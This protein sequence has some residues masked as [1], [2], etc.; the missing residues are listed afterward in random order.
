MTEARSQHQVFVVRT[1]GEWALAPLPATDPETVDLDGVLAAIGPSPEQ[2]GGP[3]RPAPDPVAPLAGTDLVGPTWMWVG[4]AADGEV[5]VEEPDGTLLVL[6]GPDLELLHTID[7]IRTVDDVVA[8]STVADAAGRLARLAGSGRVVWTAPAEAGAVEPTPEAEPAPDYSHLPPPPA[9]GLIWPQPVAPVAPAEPAEVPGDD[10]IPVYAI[11]PVDVGPLLSLGML[12][13]TARHW[14]DGALNERYE[15]RK[16]ETAASFLDHLAGRQ[17]PAVLLCSDYVWSLAHNLEAAATAR[18][19]CPDLLV[20]HGG[21]SAPKYADDAARFLSDHPAVADVLVRGEGEEALCDLLEALDGPDGWTTDAGRLGTVGGITF[22]AAD[23]EVVRTE[24]RPRIANLDSIP[25]PY[26]SGEF[27]GIPGDAWKY[28]LSIET[29]RGCPYGCTF[30]DWGSATMSRIRKFDLDRVIAELEWGAR[31]G[32]HTIT[33]TD[34]N[35]GIMS[36]DVET[37]RQIAAIR[38]RVGHPHSLSWTAA[39]NT[40]KHLVKIMDILVDSG[41]TVST[42]LS[43]QTIDPTTLEILARTNISTDHYVKLAADYRRRGYP[44]QGDLMLGLPGQTFDTYKA[45]LQFMLDHEIM[46]RS[47]PVQMLPNAPMNAPEYRAEHGI[48][49]GEDNLV[50]STHSF[51][52]DERKRMWRFRTVDTIAERMA[53]LRHVMRFLQW[54]HGIAATDLADR[55][56]AVTDDDPLRYP[57]VSW[58]FG[59]FDL[60]PTVAVGWRT[61][62]GEIA[63]LLRDEFGLDPDASDLRCVLDLQEF[64]M[65]VP[66]R[67]FPASIELPHD[68]TAYYRSATRELYTTGQAGLPEAPLASLG[69]ATFTITGDPLGL[70][71]SGIYLHGD[72]RSEIMQGDFHIGS[73]VANEL[74]SPLMRVLPALSYFGVTS[75][76]DEFAD[77]MDQVRDGFAGDD[78]DEDGVIDTVGARVT[79]SISPRER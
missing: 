19:I 70:C 23:G 46:V 42:S 73:A 56:L 75:L 29:N 32:V 4:A 38:E 6:D 18:Q 17:G 11:W 77:V 53:V 30:C 3:N 69:P 52:V 40:T 10:R 22:R 63:S 76:P 59:Y 39:K 27:D 67:S 1:P 62:Y 50:T 5:V 34:A 25:S 14:K 45:D 16:P 41:I 9:E 60:L 58:V 43:L 2:A 79:V 49:V 12:T 68:Y 26:L 24:D 57:T 61:F 28:C 15:I 54:E 64:L 55:V 13:A 7:H 44:L 51:T 65:P 72:S 8:S 66:G 33:L 21:P 48:E 36:R 74:E 47:W 78:E 37:T 20:V 31:L 35:F 71:T